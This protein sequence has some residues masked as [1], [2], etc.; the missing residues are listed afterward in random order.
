MRCYPNP[1]NLKIFLSEKPEK[2]NELKLID[3]YG[4]IIMETSNKNEVDVSSISEG[5]YFFQVTETNGFFVQKII[6]QH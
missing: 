5:I 1:A 2:I 4:K 6:I 3:V